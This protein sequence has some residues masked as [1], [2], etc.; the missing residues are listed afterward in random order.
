MLSPPS[1]PRAGKPGRGAARTNARLPSRPRPQTRAFPLTWTVWLDQTL[2]VHHHSFCSLSFLP[3]MAPFARPTSRAYELVIRQAPTRARLCSFKEEGSS[4]ESQ[5]S[6]SLPF[7][8]GPLHFRVARDDVPRPW[9]RRARTSL[10]PL[11]F[12]SSFGRF[13]ILSSPASSSGASGQETQF[14]T[15]APRWQELYVLLRLRHSSPE[16]RSWARICIRVIAI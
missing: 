2:I 1:V 13:R 6:P 16:E 11:P 10:V 8:C 5:L 14:R 3:S 12:G 4:S 7:S 15:R 9:A